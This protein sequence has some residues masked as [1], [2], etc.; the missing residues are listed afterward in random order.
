MG[1]KSEQSGSGEGDRGRKKKRIND[2]FRETSQK[3]EIKKYKKNFFS[4]NATI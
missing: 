1:I 2:K 3:K 4:Q